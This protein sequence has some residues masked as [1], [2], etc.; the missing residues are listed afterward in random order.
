MVRIGVYNGR[1]K[2]RGL[3]LLNFTVLNE[4]EYTNVVIGSFNLVGRYNEYKEKLVENR[5]YLI[6]IKD[7]PSKPVKNFEILDKC[8]FIKYVNGDY[9]ITYKR[10]RNVSLI[11]FYEN[12]TEEAH[13][14]IDWVLKHGKE[15]DKVHLNTFTKTVLE[16]IFHNYGYDD[17]IKYDY[18]A[19]KKEWNKEITQRVKNF[20][21]SIDDKSTNWSSDEEQFLILNM[22]KPGMTEK[23]IAKHLGRT[24]PSVA[25]KKWKIKHEYK[26]KLKDMKDRATMISEKLKEFRKDH[27]WSQR[28]LVE[29]SGISLSV[30]NQ[31]ECKS[32][33]STTTP[34]VEKL[35]EFVDNYDKEHVVEQ[36]IGEMKVVKTIEPKEEEGVP[37]IDVK[38][39]ELEKIISVLYNLKDEVAKMNENVSKLIGTNL[40][41]TGDNR[42]LRK[43]NLAR[44]LAELIG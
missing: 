8:K 21:K 20:N 33:S 1:T 7:E 6:N 44:Q 14:Y 16:K 9:V 39:M 37:E 38:V 4:L 32:Y 41:L 31:L 5:I 2:K 3:T 28:E 11:D 22:D 24:V 19:E 23:K 27:D 43:D 12:R 25:T 35:L 17:V 18:P 34:T 10:Y 42:K 40:Q 15:S 30:I 36:P 29:K 13:D 26:S